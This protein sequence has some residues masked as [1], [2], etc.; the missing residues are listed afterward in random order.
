[1]ITFAISPAGTKTCA[2]R[3]GSLHYET[4]DAEQ[5][6]AWSV[7]YIKVDNCNSDGTKPETRY[8]VMRDAL[9]ATGHKIFFSMCEVRRGR[10]NY[11]FREEGRLMSRAHANPYCKFLSI[12]SAL[13]PSI[14]I[15]YIDLSHRLLFFFFNFCRSGE[16]TT[17]LPG[18]PP[19]ATRGGP[20]ET[21]PTTGSP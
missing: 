13:V 14:P 15:P 18:P 11:Q 12:V 10:A 1:M 2:G 8:P 3:P 20:P 16:W 19:W 17:P 21:S 4:K 5:Y 7:D 9:N 6:A